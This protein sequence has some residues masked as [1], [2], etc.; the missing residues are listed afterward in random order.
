MTEQTGSFWIL[1]WP[2]RLWFKMAKMDRRVPLVY[3]DQWIFSRLLLSLPWPQ[4][5]RSSLTFFVYSCQGFFR[6]VTS[7]GEKESLFA[8]FRIGSKNNR[9]MHLQFAD[10]ALLFLE[11]SKNSM[12]ILRLVIQWFDWSRVLKLTEIGLNNDFISQAVHDFG[13]QV[14]SWPILYFRSSSSR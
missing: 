3:N 14:G 5:R 6:L 1:S 10:D 12:N 4:T 7:N 11:D 8:G 9:V 13:C 2:E